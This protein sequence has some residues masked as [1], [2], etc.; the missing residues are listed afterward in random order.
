MGGAA[1]INAVVLHPLHQVMVKANAVA[2]QVDTVVAIG[3]LAVGNF[4]IVVVGVV[5]DLELVAAF[6][7]E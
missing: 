5:E 7:H 2:A 4:P 3:E 6:G 1:E